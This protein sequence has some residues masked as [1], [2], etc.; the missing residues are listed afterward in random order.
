MSQIKIEANNKAWVVEIENNSTV[1]EFIKRL[2]LKITMKDL[3]Q[4][5]KYYYFNQSYPTNSQNVKRI[6]KGD[7][8]LFGTDCLVLFYKSFSTNY[9]YTKIG[10]IMD[11]I[12]FE[13]FS[14]SKSIE[15]SISQLN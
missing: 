11:P 7:I 6:I 14:D 8:M 3:H 5:E 1:K 4:N 9:H 13:I 12:D 15:I 2:P 10:Q